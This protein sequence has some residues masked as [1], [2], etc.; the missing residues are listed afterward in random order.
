MVLRKVYP[1]TL[2]QLFNS[3]TII[4]QLNT[5]LFEHKQMCQYLCSDFNVENGEHNKYI[6][7]MKDEDEE[8]EIYKYMSFQEFKILSSFDFCTPEEL[9]NKREGFYI[10]E[11]P[12]NIS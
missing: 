4:Q 1:S 2:Y 11:I 6:D 5:C 3:I 12:L 10:Q 9:I 8:D 7:E